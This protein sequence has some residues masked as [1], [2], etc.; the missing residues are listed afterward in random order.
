MGGTGQDC[1][2]PAHAERI[3]FTGS[4]GTELAARLD[5]PAL[6]PIAFAL[7]A[8]CFTC[9]KD[10]FASSRIAAELTQAGF[11]V[12]R[13]DFTGLGSS[14]GDFANTSFSSN[15]EDLRLAAA[16]L[17][18]HHRGPQL[19]VGH[20]LGGA[21]VLAVAT[22]VASARAVATIGAPSDV[23]HVKRLFTEHELARI[24]AEG[25]ASITLAGRQFTIRKQFLDDLAAQ[26]LTTRV[27]TMHRALLVMHS[28]IDNLVGVEHAAALFAAAKHPKSF[29]SLDRADHLLA[30]REDAVFAAQMIGTWAKRFVHDESGQAP[31]PGPT[32]QVVVSETTQGTY[33]NHVVAGDH[34]LF[35]DEPVTSGGFD[36]GPSP[37]DLL[38]SALGAC[39]SMTMRLYA[40]RK[41]IPV[42]RI[43]VEVAHAKVH[44]DDCAECAATDG[45]ARTGLV[46]RF[47][48]R[49]LFEG[50]LSQEQRIA[51]LGIADRCPV[52]RTLEA[53]S[54][55][56]TRLA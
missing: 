5:L 42:K 2:M 55:I 7:F 50:D 21:A 47:D 6:P 25:E 8:H 38:A 39:T 20:S 41:A 49:L 12:L 34:H 11:G 22:D 37:Y 14:D 10:V 40:D 30:R 53:S 18:E 29:V 54:T 15:T 23:G 51:L 45:G 13:F 52:H 3:T 36:A 43:T 24:E 46:D 31:S 26:Q 4:Q 9:S 17:A 48:R 27:A 33:L 56:V 44:A 19:L 28:P 35:A 1:A 32:S 16:W